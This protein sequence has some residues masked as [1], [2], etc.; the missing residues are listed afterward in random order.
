MNLFT[1]AWKRLNSDTPHFFRKIKRVGAGLSATGGT[2]VAP[3]VVPQVHM[4]DILI[5]IGGY[6]IVAGVVAA[7][8]AK[9]ACD[10]P[11]V[12]P[13]PKDNTPK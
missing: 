10:D 12:P 7:G 2:L 6:L 4:P 13:A 9:F 3:S 1:E 11:P 8:V 5:K